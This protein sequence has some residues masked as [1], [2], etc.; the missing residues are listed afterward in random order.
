MHSAVQK[1]IK[2]FQGRIQ[3]SS[4]ITG[5]NGSFDRDDFFQDVYF[6]FKIS[7]AKREDHA[8]FSISCRCNS[9]VCTKICQN[10]MGF[11]EVCGPS[12]FEKIAKLERV[13]S[14]EPDK[15]EKL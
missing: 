13:L 12:M 11:N 6:F 9:G 15:P 2:N 1:G 10:A 7:S 5:K 3:V 14:Q 8:S 4:G